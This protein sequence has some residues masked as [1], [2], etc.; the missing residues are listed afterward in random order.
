MRS[1]RHGIRRDFAF[2]RFVSQGLSMERRCG[3]CRAALPPDDWVSPI[4]TRIGSQTSK[5][6]RNRAVKTATVTEFRRADTDPAPVAQLVVRVEDV[7]DIES[8]VDG[9]L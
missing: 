2:E 8:A 3:R 4:P 1:A 9:M 6:E 7:A 5:I